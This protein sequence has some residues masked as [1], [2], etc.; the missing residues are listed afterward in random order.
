MLLCQVVYQRGK[1]RLVTWSKTRVTEQSSW[2][3]VRLTLPVGVTMIH[4]DAVSGLETA[5]ASSVSY[6]ALDDVAIDSA[7]CL[8]RGMPY[9]T[10]SLV[11]EIE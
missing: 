1:T 5:L 4:V 9:A 11:D 8:Q 6:I 7:D 2:T 3:Q 10:Q